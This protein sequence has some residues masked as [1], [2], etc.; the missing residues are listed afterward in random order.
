MTSGLRGYWIR[1]AADYQ[2]EDGS[3]GVEPLEAP[4]A[5][6]GDKVYLEG[7]EANEANSEDIGAD[8]FFQVAINIKDN[9]AVID[10][11]VLCVNGQ[12]IKTVH[13]VN[14]EVH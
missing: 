13:T 10:G 2:K 8:V 12:A 4:W 1:L 5:A 6:P 7:F 14:G 11:K 9:A 3:A